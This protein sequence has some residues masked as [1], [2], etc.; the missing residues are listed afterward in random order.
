MSH[1]IERAVLF[2]QIRTT[3]HKII[4]FFKVEDVILL[5]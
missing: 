1:I 4:E 2:Q 3:L 5:V